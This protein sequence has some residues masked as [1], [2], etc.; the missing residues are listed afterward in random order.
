M[1]CYVCQQLI[2][3]RTVKPEDYEPKHLATFAAVYEGRLVRRADLP[4]YIGQD[5][6]RHESCA[7]GTAKWIAIQKRRGRKRSKMLTYYLTPKKENDH[8]GAA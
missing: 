4:V 6:Y 5:T 2:V 8:D 7:P 1:L 3:P